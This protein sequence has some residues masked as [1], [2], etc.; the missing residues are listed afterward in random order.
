MNRKTIKFHDDWSRS[1]NRLSMNEKRKGILRGNQELCIQKCIVFN[2]TYP[3]IIEKTFNR[4]SQ[5]NQDLNSGVLDLHEKELQ[6]SDLSTY[7]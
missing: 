5:K 2:Y 7:E 4:S 6:N 1:P 3:Y